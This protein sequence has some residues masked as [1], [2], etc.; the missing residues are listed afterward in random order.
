MLDIETPYTFE[1]VHP[2]N[3]ELKTH[4]GVLEFHGDEDFV[5]MP[6]W[7][8]RLDQLQTDLMLNLEC[9]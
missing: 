6:N 9:R 5:Y 1:I 7:V 3:R 8:S 4:A 2:V